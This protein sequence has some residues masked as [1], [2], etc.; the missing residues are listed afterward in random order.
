MMSPIMQARVQRF[1]QNKLGFGCFIV[2]II[3]FV[4]SLAAELIANDKP[5]LVK[6]EQSLYLPVFKGYPETT[7]GAYLKPK[8]IIKT[9][10]CNN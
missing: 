4:L 6:Y 5:L 10:W 9:L 7:L 1:K 8:P 2:F 3:I